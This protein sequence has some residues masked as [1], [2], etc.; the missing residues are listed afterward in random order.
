[1]VGEKYFLGVEPGG[2]RGTNALGDSGQ[3]RVGGTGQL[4][5]KQLKKASNSD[6]LPGCGPI[7]RA[8]RPVGLD[9][10]SQP[11]QR[12][13]LLTLGSRQDGKAGREGLPRWGEEQL[14][15][16][17]LLALRSSEAPVWTSVCG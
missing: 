4:C 17:G 9:G 3:H 14:L 16:G 13:S 2:C 12:E 8:G 5:L 15:T 6:G 1:M 7:R 10:S 11:L